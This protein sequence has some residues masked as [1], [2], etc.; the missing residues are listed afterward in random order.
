MHFISIVYVTM[1]CGVATM[2]MDSAELQEPGGTR[3]FAI[4]KMDLIHFAC[5]V[6]TMTKSTLSGDLDTTLARGWGVIKKDNSF[7]AQ[8]DQ[9][10]SEKA[11]D[12][13]QEQMRYSTKAQ[14]N[15]FLV[16]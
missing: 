16:I 1:G 7:T 6:I 11:K 14:F 8:S 4:R 15:V 12:S 10:H 2:R 3:H 9:H 13:R 5:Q